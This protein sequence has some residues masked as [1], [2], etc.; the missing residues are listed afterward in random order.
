MYFLMLHCYNNL[1]AILRTAYIFPQ[2]RM[3]GE[4][5]ARGPGFDRNIRLQALLQKLEEMFGAD[6]KT[7]AGSIC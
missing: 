3:Q 7:M 6:Y 1:Y 2:A 4:A 5:I